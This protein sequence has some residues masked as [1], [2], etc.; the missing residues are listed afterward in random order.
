V[1]I[2]LGTTVSNNGSIAS[3]PRSTASRFPMLSTRP[4]KSHAPMTLS[5]H[6]ISSASTHKTSWSTEVA[7]ML[8]G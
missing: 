2:T 6:P 7:L 5:A 4:R 1:M 3:A 8:H